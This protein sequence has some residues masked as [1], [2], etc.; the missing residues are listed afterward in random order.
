MANNG[1]T[2]RA[3]RPIGQKLHS[4]NQGRY[5]KALAGNLK[6]MSHPLNAHRLDM[7]FGPVEVLLTEMERTGTNDAMPDGTVVFRPPGDDGCWYPL[8]SSLRAVCDTY[9]LVAEHYGQPAGVDSLRRLA[10]KIEVDMPLMA[11]DI[12]GARM[13]ILWM[14]EIS[15]GMTPDEFSGFIVA[16]QVRNEMIDKGVIA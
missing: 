6:P 3:Y 16:V 9:E 13:N 10:K 1:K 5:D 2:R 11:M 7:V 8:A 12:H 14:R 15:T 4:W